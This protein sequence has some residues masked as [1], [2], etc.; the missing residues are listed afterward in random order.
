MS[1]YKQMILCGVAGVLTGPW[2]ISVAAAQVAGVETGQVGNAQALP[3]ESM[4]IVVTGSRIARSGFEQPTPTTI[5]GADQ[6]AR[7]AT[8]NVADA[9]NTLPQ[10]RASLTSTTNTSVAAVVGKNVLDLRGLGGQR[11]LVLV[12]GKRFVAGT[13][14]GVVDLNFIPQAL[15]ESVDIVT[16]GASAAY[17][18]DAVAG[19]VNLRLNKSLE[20]MRVALQGGITDHGDYRNYLASI[21]LGHGFADGRGRVTLSAESAENSGI[22][23]I[24]KRDWAAGGPGTIANPA[25]TATNDEPRNLLVPAG[26]RFSN[27]STGGVINSGPLAGIQFGPGGVPLPFRYGSLVTGRTM[28]GGDGA[29]MSQD[30]PIAAA[31]KRKAFFGRASYEFSDALEVFAE[32]Y[33]A[34]TS[35]DTLSATREDTAITIRNDNAFLPDS[36]RTA[37]ADNGISTFT[38]GRFSSDYGSTST[39]GRDR[40]LRGVLGVTGKIGGT[41]SYEAFYTRGHTEQRTHG[42][43]IR[44]INNY[45]FA[46]D[47]VVDPLTGAA[48]CRNLAARAAG[49]VPINLFGDGSPS[50]QAVDYVTADLFRLAKL[51]Q[52]VVG[53]LVRGDLFDSWAGP[54]SVAVGSEYRRE[55][56]DFTTDTNAS[57]FLLAT[58]NSVPWRGGVHVK[59]VFGEAVV[60]LARDM[61]FARSIDLNLAG[62]MTDYSTSGTVATWKAGATWEVNDFIKFR[63][64]ISRD[65]RAPSLVDLF[66]GDIQNL[67]NIVDTRLNEN[68][69]ARTITGGN[70]FLDPERAITKT[71]GV[72]VTGLIP[73]LRASIDY[74]DIQVKDAL[75]TLTPDTIIRRCETDTPSLCS[76]ITRDAGDKITFIRVA[77]ANLQSIRNTGFDFELDYSFPLAGGTVRIHPTVNYVD[78]LTYAD[79]VNTVRLDGSI[80][81]PFRFGTN[82]VPRWRGSFM[83]SY[84]H[85]PLSL[86]LL[87]RYIGSANLNNSYTSKDFNI[88]RVPSVVY[89]DTSLSYRFDEVKG[90]PQVFFKINNLFDKDPPLTDGAFFGTNPTMYDVVGRT[91]S[92][93][94]RMSF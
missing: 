47:S 24:R 37:M 45:A 94:V 54:V 90:V 43:G 39:V 72:V 8:P 60:P 53:G 89:A 35:A 56:V 79:G 55:K 74:Y 29:Y 76:F 28:I 73:R 18:S 25:Y 66:S 12:D 4:E 51:D 26:V 83:G 49:C 40:S 77:P 58:G 80:A 19:V 11:T 69:Q 92:L 14:E 71:V 57:S 36:I 70:R 15:V 52:H 91:Y 63:G 23:S 67:V 6:L 10:L 32:G 81:T 59:E 65:I 82:G 22:T 48:V 75:S 2:T 33:F 27:S 50:P 78:R 30:L 42:Y 86:N 20:G 46:L 64:T 62:R 7:Q 17:G 21:A 88:L 16:G 87:V 85:G 34:R 31:T 68:Y 13:L 5:L 9:I 84:D 3:E 41:W 38:M 93:G 44:L 61:S 1:K